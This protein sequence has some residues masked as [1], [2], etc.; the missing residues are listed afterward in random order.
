[1]ICDLGSRD[2]FCFAKVLVQGEVL[3]WDSI[4]LRRGGRIEFGVAL[5][6][7]QRR[8]GNFLVGFVLGQV[9][10]QCHGADDDGGDDEDAQG[11]WRK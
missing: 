1:M 5:R 6:R 8:S 4:R 10:E 11:V 9:V 7:I 2:I 3:K